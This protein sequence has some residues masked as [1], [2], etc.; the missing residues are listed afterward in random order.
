MDGKHILIRPPPNTG[1]YYFNYMHSFSVVLLAVVDANYKFLYIDV[2]C[3]GRVS[4]GGVFINSSLFAALG[5]NA[6]NIPSHEPLLAKVFPLP[7]MLVTD[8]AFP[9]K[10]NIQKPFG[11]AGFTN[12][13]RI[14]SHRLS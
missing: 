6:L 1:L 12:D 3:N 13:K 2:G 10:E 14:F 4:Y 9:L 11:Q 8:N 7:Y 5:S